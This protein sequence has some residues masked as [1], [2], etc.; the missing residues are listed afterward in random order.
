M[1]TQQSEERRDDTREEAKDVLALLTVAFK[2][3]CRISGY[4]PDQERIIASAVGKIAEG[5]G[6]V[7]A[8]IQKRHEMK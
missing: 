3:T 8:F 6:C 5:M 7:A 2:M 4:G 1:N